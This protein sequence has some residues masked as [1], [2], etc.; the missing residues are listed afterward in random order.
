MPS[1]VPEDS[2]F[3]AG[4]LPETQVLLAG[5]D[6]LTGLSSRAG[7]DAHYRLAV[8]RARR[9]GARLAVGV[10]VLDVDAATP[11]DDV[12]GHDLVIVEAGRRLRAT[13]RETDL[14]ARI[15]ETRF[16]FIAEE[17]TATGAAS[18][19]ARALRALIPG[20]DAAGAGVRA[21]VGL[22]LAGDDPQSLAALLRAA[23]EALTSELPSAPALP[24]AANAENFGDGDGARS[25]GAGRVTLRQA[26]RRAIGWISLAALLGL[27]LAAAPADWRNRWWPVDASVEQGWATLRGWSP[28]L[29][30]RP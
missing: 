21:R 27:A 16:A 6:L 30:L 13:L 24:D 29:R 14:L 2:P 18:I 23:E 26:A 1:S 4:V 10:A 25:A 22:A 7:L 12:F 19:G 28:P 11:L 5:Q 20:A 9:S 17:M 8:A 15:G 3:R